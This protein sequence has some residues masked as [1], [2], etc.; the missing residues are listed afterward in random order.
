MEIF[1]CPG[2]DIIKKRFLGALDLTRGII[3]FHDNST[4][5]LIKLNDL[6]YK[7][8]FCG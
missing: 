2:L 3:E 8:Q 1:P 6:G 4:N 7:G 5:D